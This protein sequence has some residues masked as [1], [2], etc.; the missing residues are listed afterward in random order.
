[1]LFTLIEIAISSSSIKN[2]ALSQKIIPKIQKCGPDLTYTLGKGI[3]TIE[4]SG[5]MDNYFYGYETP[6][7][8][9]RTSITTIILPEGLETIG[10]YSFSN[11]TQLTTI[12][13]P[14]KCYQHWI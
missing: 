3:L 6:W 7:Y 5:K 2:E 8:I 11:L 14:Q 12:E 1:M 4:G 13:I 10:S 9:F